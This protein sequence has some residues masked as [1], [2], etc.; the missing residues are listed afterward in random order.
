MQLKGRQGFSKLIPKVPQPNR[1]PYFYILHER[2][3]EQDRR[4]TDPDSEDSGLLSE[5]RTDFPMVIGAFEQLFESI[6]TSDHADPQPQ[7]DN[8][9][10]AI[11]AEYAEDINE[12]ITEENGDYAKGYGVSSVFIFNNLFESG[13]VTKN[14]GG[15]YQVSRGQS[16]LGKFLQTFRETHE[17]LLTNDPD[18]V[19][20]LENI[21]PSEDTQE[22]GKLFS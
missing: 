12:P 8:L 20:N 4:T 1:K 16:A 10:M 3:H 19:E 11:F 14:E 2:G 13:L 15:G 18:V 22:V 17:K 21:K 7:I 5:V 6:D 9:I